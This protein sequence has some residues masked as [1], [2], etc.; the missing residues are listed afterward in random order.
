MDGGGRPEVLLFYDGYERRAQPGAL[1]GAQSQARRFARLAYRT[2]L[3]KQPRTGFYTWFLM[4]VRALHDAD[5]RVRVNDFAAARRNPAAPIGAAGYPSVFDKIAD[6]P[7]PRLIGPGVFTTPLEF[8]NLFEDQ[9]NK[10]TLFT[11]DWHAGIFRPW[12]GDHIRPW[13]G[14]FDVNAFADARGA[15]KQF[16]VLIYDK[17]YFDRDRAYAETIAPFI[18]MLTARGLSYKVLRYGAHHYSDYLRA[19]RASRCMAFFAH[20]ET[21]GMAYQECLASNLPIF[22]WNEGVWLDPNAAKL[23]LGTIACTSVPYF[24]ERCGV[25]FTAA[26]M[27]ERWDPFYADLARYEPRAFVADRLSLAESAKLYLNAYREAGASA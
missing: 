3:R 19:I 17:I 27:R 7:N 13:F 16:D 21:Q 12:Y 5:V 11:C 26:T 20:Q 25:T 6:L 4:L 15:E 24:D 1:G 22:A 10:L 14:G 2:A 8:P 23:G 9:R 18:E